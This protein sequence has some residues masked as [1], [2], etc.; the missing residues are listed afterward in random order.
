VRRLCAI[1]GALLL[2]GGPARA[3]AQEYPE[4]VIQWGVTQ[5]ESC[6][7]IAKAV[8]GTARHAQ[9][10]T[11]YNRVVCLGGAPLAVQTLV[12]P[13]KVTEVARARVGALAPEVRHKPPGGDWGTA[14]PGLKLS[15]NSSVNTLDDANATIVFVDRTR[16]LL[17]ENTLVVIFGSAASSAVRST[18]LAASVTIDEGEVRAALAA[19]RGDDA[20]EVDV[21]GG[22]RVSAASRDTVL[23]KRGARTNVSVFDGRTRVKSQG[24]SVDV[25]SG[26]GTRFFSGKAP[27]PPRPLPAAPTWSVPLSP[28]AL[29]LGD[30]ATLEASWEKSSQAAAYRVEIARDPAFFELVAR[31]EVKPDVTSF[32]AE[33]V[34][35]GTFY[36]RVRVLDAEEFLGIASTTSQVVVISARA[37]SLSSSGGDVLTVHPYGDLSFTSAGAGLSLALDDLALAPAPPS[38]PLGRDRPSAITVASGDA[39]RRF[40]LAYSSVSATLEPG[41]GATGEVAVRFVGVSGRGTFERMAPRLLGLGPAGEVVTVALDPSP[42]DPSL[43]LA[44]VPGPLTAALVVDAWGRTLGSFVEEGAPDGARAPVAPPRGAPLRPLGPIV[45]PWSLDPAVPRLWAPLAPDAVYLSVGV[46]QP[47]DGAAAGVQGLAE[48][49]GSIGDLSVEAAIRT[50]DSLPDRNENEVAWLGARYRVW[51]EEDGLLDVGPGVRLG[52]PTSDGGPSFQ[53]EA[54]VAAGGRLG[55]WRW[56]GSVTF[57]LDGAPVAYGYVPGLAAG[58]SL[59]PMTWF[60]AFAALDGSARQVRSQPVGSEASTLERRFDGGLTVGAEAGKVV[61]GGLFVRATPFEAPSPALQFAASLGFRG[62]ATP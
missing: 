14:S 11:R 15:D 61:F 60:R 52:I 31:E 53:A 38:L 32:R 21:A 39:R 40:T 26:F 59:E 13:A 50:E 2:L 9:L 25:E 23:A 16:V 58:V 18:S 57:D 6:E 46:Q 45:S 36:M 35:A 24:E 56:L 41:T 42:N 54:G 55:M 4:E 5:G 19:L 12:L 29:D 49:T 44:K 20:V 43:A 62:E 33:K 28:V 8:Y 30:G 17:A 3:R 51:S 48:I 1:F 37:E 27:E 34:P 7:D 47:L 22:G 10:V